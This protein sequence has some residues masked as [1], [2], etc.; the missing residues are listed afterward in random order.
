MLLLLSGISAR[1]S[2]LRFIT[3]HTALAIYSADFTMTN[4]MGP[5]PSFLNT[6]GLVPLG[7]HSSATT[8][9]AKSTSTYYQPPPHG[10]L[11]KLGPTLSLPNTIH[12]LSNPSSSSA[13]APTPSDP[14]PSPM[15][16]QQISAPNVNDAGG[17]ATR[18]V[19][20]EKLKFRLVF[21]LWPAM[22]GLTMAL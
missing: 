7:S 20:M 5:D 8:K 14:S 2:H 3:Q 9:S 22:I 4:M 17:T 10:T 13:P 1:V 12:T 6:S 11:R 18:R 15:V 19:D 16:P 21:I